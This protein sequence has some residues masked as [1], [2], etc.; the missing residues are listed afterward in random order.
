MISADL[1]FKINAA[2]FGFFSAQFLLLPD[3]LMEQNFVAG[4]Y[5]LDK[6]HYFIMRGFGTLG[7]FF[8]ALMVQ[9]DAAKFLP[10]FTVFHF[11]FCAVL[12]WYAQIMMETKPMHL[13]ASG[14]TAV[15]AVL[16]LLA[17]ASSSKSKSN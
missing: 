2:F 6:Y 15:I 1:V 14:G 3:M 12:P 11:T 5:T 9:L 7:L 4:S 17:L 13:V 16:H 8:C 10:F